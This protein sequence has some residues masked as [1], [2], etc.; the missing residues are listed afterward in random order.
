MKK[1][2][3]TNKFKLETPAMIESILCF[4]KDKLKSVGIQLAYIAI[5]MFYAYKEKKTPSWARN[6]ILGSLGYLLAPID[7]IPD[8]TPVLGFTDDFGVL[9]FGLVAISCY[10]TD[11]IRSRAKEHMGEWFGIKESAL[12]EEIDQRL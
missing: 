1:L 11:P 9:S 4:V 10:I 7:S 12:F 6:I 3:K 5:M 8:L 2:F